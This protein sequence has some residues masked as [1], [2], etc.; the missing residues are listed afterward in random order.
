MLN[1]LD[2]LDTIPPLNGKLLSDAI[3]KALEEI[4]GEQNQKLN[5]L[6]ENVETIANASKKEGAQFAA[7][8][9]GQ[10]ASESNAEIEIARKE[11]VKACNQSLYMVEYGLIQDWDIFLAREREHTHNQLGQG[12]QTVS[13]SFFSF[14]F[15]VPLSSI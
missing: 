11:F 15:L 7:Y 8:D 10:S 9:Q 13:C 14:C 5:Q 4:T 12:V 3:R 6:Q 1:L 2:Q